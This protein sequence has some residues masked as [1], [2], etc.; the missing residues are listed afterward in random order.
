MMRSRMV[1]LE[2]DDAFLAA[3]ARADDATARRIA[4]ADPDIVRRIESRDPT[5]LIDFAGS[6]DANA[7]RLLPDLGVDI[8]VARTQPPWSRGLTALHDAT[9]HC[10]LET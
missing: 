1:T 4:A 10:R 9:G 5:L 6:A 2:G 8:A 7:V 3:C